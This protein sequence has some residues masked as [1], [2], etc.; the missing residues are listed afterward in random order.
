MLTL[1][2][3]KPELSVED[4]SDILNINYK[5]ASEHISRLA[6]AGLVLKRADG[7]SV[8]HKLTKRAESILM[9]LR[10]LE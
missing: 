9:F 3:S 1:L 7:S 10:T 5:T 6:Y 8:R 2:K 4:I